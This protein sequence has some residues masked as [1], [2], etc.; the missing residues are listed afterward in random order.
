MNLYGTGHVGVLVGVGVGIGVSVG[1]GIGVGV[2]VGVGIGV[3][4]GVGLG[5]GVAVGVG[6]GVGVA[7]GI[8]SGV[9]VG[10]GKPE[11]A[12]G[13]GRVGPRVGSGGAVSGDVWGRVVAAG[14]GTKMF[15]VASAASYLEWDENMDVCGGTMFGPPPRAPA[16]RARLRAQKSA[17][18]SGT[19]ANA[20][21]NAGRETPGERPTLPDSERT[22]SELPPCPPFPLQRSL[23]VAPATMACLNVSSRD[24]SS[25]G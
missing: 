18:Q 8:G 25:A 12:V 15:G 23:L 13:V 7:V 20:I 2:S 19:A 14:V 11:P 6:V 17:T 1:V 24:L 9:G 10:D 21:S 3:G 4:L 16:L 5:V 22:A